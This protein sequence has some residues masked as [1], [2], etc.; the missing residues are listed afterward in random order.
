MVSEARRL[1]H[2]DRRR[3]ERIERG[4]HATAVRI[5]RQLEREPD[6]GWNL[7]CAVRNDGDRHQAPVEVLASF[8]KER[9]IC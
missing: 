8:W 1:A 4:I 9:L 2:R 6:L 5:A 3:I 7:K